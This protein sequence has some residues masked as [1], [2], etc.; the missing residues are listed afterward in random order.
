LIDRWPE[1]RETFTRLLEAAAAGTFDSALR[2]LDD[3]TLAAPLPSRTSRIFAL[4]GN[5]GKHY[6]DSAKV[7][8]GFDDNAEE[9][10]QRRRA[11]GPWGF[12]VLPDTVTGPNTSISPPGGIQKLDYEGEIA[13]VLANGGRNRDASDLRVWGF[14]ALNDFS[15]RDTAFQLGEPYDAGPMAWTLQK[16]F[17]TGSSIGPWLVVDEAF[18]VDDLKILLRVNGEVRQTGST[19]EMIFTFGET[20]EHLSRFLTLK[21]GDLIASGTP[22]GTAVE[23]GFD[24]P[25]LSDGDTT[26]VEVEGAGIL[27]NKIVAAT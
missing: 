9:A 15:L 12:L 7:V 26:E 6:Q 4:G 1:L 25:Y 24:G 21:R 8:L 11:Q 14:T 2:D 22:S 19:S 20:F 3:D 27:R 16:N 23:R 5:F 10:L 17:D 13:V 18:D